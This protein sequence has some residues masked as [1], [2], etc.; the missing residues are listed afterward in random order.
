[1]K[2]LKFLRIRQIHSTFVKYE[3]KA[4]TDNANKP[5]KRMQLQENIL[6]SPLHTCSNLD[7]KI[8][9]WVKRY[10]SLDEVP[11]RVTLE[12]IQKA[13]STARIRVSFILMGI[14][15]LGFI[16]AIIMGKR[17]T[18]SGKNILTERLKHYEKIKA[19]ANAAKQDSG[20]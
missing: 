13:H 18:A 7:K 3:E 10:P 5:P 12:C 15:I 8:L 2:E 9:V 6:G 11:D 14:T 1:M 4:P 20:K 16:G 17:D 19:E